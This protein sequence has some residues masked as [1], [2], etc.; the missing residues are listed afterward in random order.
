MGDDFAIRLEKWVT[1]KC[2]WL[3]ELEAENARLREALRVIADEDG[4]QAIICIHQVLARAA[5]AAA[6]PA[7]TQTPDSLEVRADASTG[8]GKDY[9][10]DNPVCDCGAWDGTRAHAAYV[11]DTTPGAGHAVTCPV[12]IAHPFAAA[13]P[14][15]SE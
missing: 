8:L 14:K 2:D 5:L 6:S 12:R 13:S 9:D 11:M 4:T 15:E 3:D 10:L 7:P 1:V